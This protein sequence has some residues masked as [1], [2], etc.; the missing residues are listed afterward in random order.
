MH[1]LSPMALSVSDM[2][3]QGKIL[4]N[5]SLVIIEDFISTVAGTEIATNC[6]ATIL[7]ATTDVPFTLINVYNYNKINECYI[8]N[9]T[10]SH[11]YL[12]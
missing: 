8:V 9:D 3:T 4:T 11:V 2:Q 7:V 10:Q 12:T 6:V 1:D 5:A